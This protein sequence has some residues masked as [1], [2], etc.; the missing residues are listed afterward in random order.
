MAKDK[1][2]DELIAGGLQRASQP[3]GGPNTPIVKAPPQQGGLDKASQYDMFDSEVARMLG[4]DEGTLVKL[5]DTRDATSKAQ[6]DDLMKYSEYSGLD[7]VM[8]GLAGI[9]LDRVPAGLA[10]A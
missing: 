7:K 6:V 5:R 4:E 8:A 2:V 3:P 10:G 9:S 1:M